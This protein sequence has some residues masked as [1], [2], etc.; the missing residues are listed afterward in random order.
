MKGFVLAILGVIMEDCCVS[1][2]PFLILLKICFLLRN[3]CRSKIRII[4]LN[5]T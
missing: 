3:S 4:K 1:F 5:K 2:S